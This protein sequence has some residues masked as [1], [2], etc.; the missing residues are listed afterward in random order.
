ME[1]SNLR[2]PLLFAALAVFTNCAR[3]T[4]YR[5]A[6]NLP[7]DPRLITAQNSDEELA[8]ASVFGEMMRARS[9]TASVGLPAV[10][11]WKPLGPQ[12]TCGWF[13]RDCKGQYT[14]NVRA[15]A[16]DR[17][18]PDLVYLGANT[19]GLWKT[20]DG[21]QNWTPISDFASSLA[22]SSI[23]IDPGDANT[24]YAGTALMILKSTDAGATWIT[25]P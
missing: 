17:T 12:P 7:V 1:M 8:A 21:G 5:A 24:V 20:K 25:V 13:F 14:G 6:A 2:A 10:T 11:A 18:N 3:P 4:A 15:L 16:V 23:V 19:G 9:H 22:I